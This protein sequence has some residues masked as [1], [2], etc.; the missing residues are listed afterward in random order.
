MTL[1]FGV[2]F[3]KIKFKSGHRSIPWIRLT[4]VLLPVM[5][6]VVYQIP[7]G[8]TPTGKLI[9]FIVTYVLWDSAYTVSDVPIYNL[10]TMM[11]TNLNERNS[12]LSLARLFALIGAFITGMLTPI[13]VSERVGFSFGNTAIVVALLAALTMIPIA[14]SAQERFILR[15]KI[16]GMD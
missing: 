15:A 13:L 2:V 1:F 7:D 12:I 5:T 3:D 14:F 8:L 9:W 10:V 4:L 11:T 16:K 6:V